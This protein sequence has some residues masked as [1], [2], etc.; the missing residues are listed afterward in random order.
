[1][2]PMSTTPDTGQTANTAGQSADTS[3][4]MSAAEVARL[5]DVHE[6]TV[7]RAI[8][9]GKLRAD[10]RDGVFLVSRRDMEV[11]RTETAQLPRRRS[12]RTQTPDTDTSGQ[13]RVLSAPAAPDT[14]ALLRKMLEREQERAERLADELRETKERLEDEIRSRADREPD[15]SGTWKALHEQERAD[16]DRDRE[17]WNAEREALTQRAVRLEDELRETRDRLED[18]VRRG[19]ELEYWRGQA[20]AFRDQRDRAE[21]RLEA[22]ETIALEAA[23]SP[24][25]VT[26]PHTE[27]VFASWLRKRRKSQG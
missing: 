3:G 14:S 16:R 10:K 5:V 26:G 19:A 27:S 2:P 11:W 21:L 24:A 20:D 1:M 4:L 7:R 12:D 17:T 18:E 13:V 8:A 22:A 25:P 9:S 15:T 6:K 23:S